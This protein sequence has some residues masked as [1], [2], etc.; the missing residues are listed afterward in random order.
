MAFFF[1]KVPIKMKF[2]LLEEQ[3]FDYTPV[4][5]YYKNIHWQNYTAEAICNAINTN[6]I[7]FID[8]YIAKN[9]SYSKES[10]IKNFYNLKQAR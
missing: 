7:N 5:E 1:K 4:A 3:D 2:E 10:Y 8:E 6:N 9:E